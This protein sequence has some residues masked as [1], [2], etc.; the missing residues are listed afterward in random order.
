[1]IIN[2]VREVVKDKDTEIK[3]DGIRVQVIETEDYPERTRNKVESNT[4]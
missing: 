1:L 4:L 2:R 3:M